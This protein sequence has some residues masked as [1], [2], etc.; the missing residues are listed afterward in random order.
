[1]EVFKYL[2]SLAMAEGAE[3][4]Q[5]VFEGSKVLG[6]VKSIL[7]GRTMNW[8]TKKSFYSK[9]TGIHLIFRVYLIFA[10]HSVKMF[11]SL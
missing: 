2:G 8:G 4:Q 9:P 3:V 11:L 1:M 5:R 10:I 7:K 6:A